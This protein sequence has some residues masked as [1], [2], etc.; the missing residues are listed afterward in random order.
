MKTAKLNLKR[1]AR[2][3]TEA[4]KDAKA[5]E[6]KSKTNAWAKNILRKV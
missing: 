6:I 3:A 2:L 5:R 1:G 4:E